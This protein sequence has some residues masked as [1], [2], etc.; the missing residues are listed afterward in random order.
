[1]PTVLTTG[2]KSITFTSASGGGEITNDG[3]LPVTVR[4]VCWNITGVPTITDNHSSDGSGAVIFYSTLTDLT[5]PTIYYVR[6][7]ATNSLGL[8]TEIR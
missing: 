6:A 3:G 1:M 7:Y 4:G 2:L 5:I 8:H